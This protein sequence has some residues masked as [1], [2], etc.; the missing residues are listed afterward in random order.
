MA[1]ATDSYCNRSS[2]ITDVMQP[3]ATKCPQTSRVLKHYCT[4]GNDRLARMDWS[5]SRCSR[6]CT[7]ASF[8]SSHRVSIRRI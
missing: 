5:N 8:S 1:R 6:C 7:L 4:H 3:L 2:A